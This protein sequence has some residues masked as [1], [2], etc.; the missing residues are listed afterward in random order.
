[1]ALTTVNSGG[2]KDDS[3]VNAD[4][5]S[6]AAIALSKLASTPAVLTGS[7]NNTITTVTGANAIQ[8]EANLTFDGTSLKLGQTQS[9]INLNTSDASDD[10]FL[11]INGGGDASQSRGAGITFYGN[12]VGSNEGRLWIGAGNSGSANGFIN[13]NTA[14]LERVRIDS[15]GSLLLGTTS[16]KDVGFTHKLQLEGTSTA[17]HSF[18]I[19]ANRADAHAAHID[20]AKSRGA[21]VGSNTVVQDDDYLGHIVFRGAD[22]TDLASS[23]AQISAAVDGT[24]GSNDMPGRLEF[25]TTADG[26]ASPTERMRIDSGGRLLTS[27]QTTSVAD[28][29]NLHAHIQ[30]HSADGNALSIGRYSANAWDPYISFFKSRNATIGSNG[31]IVQDGDTL[32]RI[33]WYGATGSAWDHAAYHAVKVDGT[34]GASNDMPVRY[35][36][37]NQADGQQ[38]P[39]HTMSLRASGDLEVKT[40]NLVIGTSGKGIDFSANSHA[41]G[42]TSETLDS[43]EEGTWTP[44]I[45]FNDGTTGITYDTAGADATGGTYT[46]IGRQVTVH[47]TIKLTSKGS[48][49]GDAR[50]HGLPFTSS[51]DDNNRGSGSVGYIYN[52][53]LSGPLL[54]L[55]ERGGNTKFYLRQIASDWDDSTTLTNSNFTDTS[56]WF[57]TLTYNT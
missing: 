18:S 12:E 24:P 10:K 29:S 1:M 20:I 35:D 6:N 47:G 49:T 42:M 37:H 15:S 41:T 48:S 26:A 7:T 2:I 13:F 9:K 31:T 19:I 51:G 22:G 8:G 11:S 57:F 52:M 38:H 27:G 32:G 25:K 43:Y 55:E 3:I 45:S 4:I 53:A 28:S 16:S 50:I 39:A 33:S 44:S 36:W 23:G 5:K 30:S 56:R 40:G 21:S 34:P 14:G 17:P 46:K 54:I